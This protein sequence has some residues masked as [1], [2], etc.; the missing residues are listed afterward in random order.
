MIGAVLVAAF[1]GGL[2]VLQAGL[3]DLDAPSAG[4]APVRAA[5][6]LTPDGEI[7]ALP[8][9]GNV[10]IRDTSGND[11]VVMAG[12]N[13]VDAY[14]RVFV[15]FSNS[16]AALIR[17]DYSPDGKKYQIVKEIDYRKAENR[18]NKFYAAL[19]DD[20]MKIHSDVCDW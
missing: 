2:L 15:R 17:M 11:V 19:A 20:A 16:E 3:A 7:D 4:R 18:E 8:T 13:G 12:T 1:Q 9:V 5:T 6:Y 14:S 10:C